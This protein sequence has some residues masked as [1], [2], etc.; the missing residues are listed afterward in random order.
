MDDDLQVFG[1]P[2]RRRP[3][4]NFTEQVRVGHQI[5]G[6]VGTILCDSRKLNQHGVG[7]RVEN[8]RDNRIVFGGSVVPW[9]IGQIPPGTCA[10]ITDPQWPLI[11]VDKKSQLLADRFPLR[12]RVADQ[13]G[14][15]V[16]QVVKRDVATNT[17]MERLLQPV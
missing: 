7:V 13:Y 12:L 4:Q 5:R 11:N 14:G 10:V 3:V 2:A 16:P 15:S 17:K 1:L 8:S 6:G 9:K